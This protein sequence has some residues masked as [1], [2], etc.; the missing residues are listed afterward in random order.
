MATH[1]A[2]CFSERMT[3]SKTAVRDCIVVGAGAAGMSASLTLARARRSTLVIDAGEQSNLTASSVGGENDRR[4]PSRF[5]AAG[6]AALTAYGSVE[7]CRGEV[8]R[9]VRDDDGNFTVTFGDG[10]RERA[11]SMVLAPGMDY[12]YPRLPGMDERWGSSVFH[13]PFCHD[14]DIGDRPLG[15]LGGGAGG[16]QGALSL[17]AGIDRVTLLTNGSELTDQQR[18]QLAVG[19]VGLDE[20][21]ISGLDGP[22]SELRAAVFDDGAELPLSTL[23]VKTS[24]HQ[25]SSLARDLGASLTEPDEIL[26][27]E[28]IKVDALSRTGTPGLY[29]AGDAASSV[30]PSMAAAVASGHLA[31][32]SAAVHLAAGF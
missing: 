5:Y 9:G 21:P 28:A 22:G 3:E 6:S 20:R 19:K 14:W 2:G 31:G 15:V 26:D 10:R 12:R 27:V 16:V 7:L 25:R 32:T 18:R 11:R 1:V 24:L 13:C 23:L 30:L 8:A 4:P 29:A 17:R